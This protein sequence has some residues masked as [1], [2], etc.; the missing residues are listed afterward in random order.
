MTHLDIV[1]KKRG[2]SPI[3]QITNLKTELCNT[4]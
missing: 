2:T 1:K 3:S 4:T